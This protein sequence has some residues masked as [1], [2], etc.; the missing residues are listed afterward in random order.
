MGVINDSHRR[1]VAA[2]EDK[3]RKAQDHIERQRKQQADEADDEADA[4][5][6]GQHAD[7]DDNGQHLDSDDEVEEGDGD[8]HDDGESGYDDDKAPGRQSTLMNLMGEVPLEKDGPKANNPLSHT[9]FINNM[10]HGGHIGRRWQK[11]CRRGR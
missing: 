8:H 10:H 2:M 3:L 1:L 6:N 7:V 4:D 11:I 5:Y 9:K